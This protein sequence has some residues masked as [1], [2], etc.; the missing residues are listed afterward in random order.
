[1]GITVLSIGKLAAGQATYYLEQARRRVDVVA[2]V[3][4]GVEDYYFDGPK[5][6]ASGSARVPSCS[7]WP[8]RWPR[9]L[10]AGCLEA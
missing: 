9:R 3:G 7:G 2:S 1:L 10:Y 5:R 6:R 8:E 4:T